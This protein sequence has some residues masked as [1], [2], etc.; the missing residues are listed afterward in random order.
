M[1]E[2]SSKR[3][4]NSK[5]ASLVSDYQFIFI[6][7][8]VIERVL[9][10]TVSSDISRLIT[11]YVHLLKR[12]D[13]FSQTVRK[14]RN[15][16]VVNG[17]TI[18]K[19][20]G[21]KYGTVLCGDGGPLDRSRWTKYEVVLRI[22]KIVYGFHIGYVFGS[23]Q[24]VDFKWRLGDGRNKKNSVGIRIGWNGF[25]LYD[26]NHYDKQSKCESEDGPSTFPKQGQIWRISWNLIDNEMKIS[27]LNQQET[28]WIPMTHYAMKQEHCDIIPAFTLSYKDESITLLSECEE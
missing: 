7:V 3:K 10:T 23:I 16:V 15:I 24:E 5:P 28:D 26:E 12:L 4:V 2:L 6:F 21:N 14:S 1:N 8:G 18:T 9:N 13:S 17:V 27:V 25:Y 11:R 19:R 22:N 20:S